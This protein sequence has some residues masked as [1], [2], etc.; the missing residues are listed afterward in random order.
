MS[1][2]PATGFI[3]ALF[4]VPAVL[5]CCL[6]PVV[7]FAL[8]SGAAGGLAGWLSGLDVGAVALTVAVGGVTVAWLVRRRRGCGRS[9]RNPIKERS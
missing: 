9:T 1:D 3:T 6:G 2:K 7:A 5:L 8:L 4:A